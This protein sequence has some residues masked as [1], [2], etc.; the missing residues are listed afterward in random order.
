RATGRWL[1]GPGDRRPRAFMCR[2]QPAEDDA[3]NER[4]PEPRGEPREDLSNH[5]TGVRKMRASAD[6]RKYC[7]FWRRRAANA[8][9][10]SKPAT[11][12]GRVYTWL[13]NPVSQA[14]RDRRIVDGRP[15]QRVRMAPPGRCLWPCG[16]DEPVAVVRTR[17]RPF[18]RRVGPGALR[19]SAVSR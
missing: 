16:R 4:R 1:A 3:E 8:E 7:A 18:L 11:P 12:R 15:R 19:W 5:A 9:S 13:R 10:L 17:S 14:H 6:R 2:H